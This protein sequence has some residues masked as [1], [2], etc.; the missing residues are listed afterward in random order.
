M[1]IFKYLS[2]EE[3]PTRARAWVMTH[4]GTKYLNYLHLRSRECGICTVVIC[5]LPVVCTSSGES[6]MSVQRG[7]IHSTRPMRRMQTEFGGTLPIPAQGPALAP[8]H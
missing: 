6:V 2:K 7:T 8:S 4:K 5:A 1:I 3:V